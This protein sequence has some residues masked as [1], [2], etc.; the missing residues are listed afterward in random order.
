MKHKKFLLFVFTMAI[1]FGTIFFVQESYALEPSNINAVSKEKGYTQRTLYRKQFFINNTELSE[2]ILSDTPTGT[3]NY[4]GS[5]NNCG[6]GPGGSKFVGYSLTDNPSLKFT[7][8]SNAANSEAETIYSVY[9]FNV[10][11]AKGEHVAEIK[12]STSASCMTTYNSN[13]CTVKLPNYTSEGNFSP[14]GW[15]E[16]GSSTRIPMGSN[17]DVTKNNVTLYANSASKHEVRYNAGAGSS[18]G[19]I[20]CASCSSDDGLTEYVANGE[21][22]IA[23]LIVAPPNSDSELFG[24]TPLGSSV[25]VKDR[26]NQTEIIYPDCRDFSATCKIISDDDLRNHNVIINNNVTLRANFKAISKVIGSCD[27]DVVDNKLKIY[28]STNSSCTM[29]SVNPTNIPWRQFKDSITD[30]EI[31]ENVIAAQDSSYVFSNLPNVTAIDLSKLD[32]SGVTNMSHMFDGDK[33]LTN[34][35]FPNNFAASSVTDMSSMFKDCKELTSLDLSSFN[36]TGVTNMSDMFNGCKKLENLIVNSDTFKTNNVVNMSNMIKD[37]GLSDELVSNLHFDTSSEN[38][39]VKF[40]DESPE[41]NVIDDDSETKT[42][43]ILSPI[44]GG[45]GRYTYELV[46]VDP[47]T[48]GITIDGDKIKVADD[49]NLGTYKVVVNVIDKYIINSETGTNKTTPITYTITVKNNGIPAPNEKPTI[50]SEGGNNFIYKSSDIVLKCESNTSYTNGESSVFLFGYSYSKSVVPT[51]WDES[52]DNTYTITKD[53]QDEVGKRYYFCQEVA[54]KGDIV[55]DPTLSDFLDISVTNATITFDMSNGGT[56]NGES[57]TVYAKTGSADLYSTLMGN[58]PVN[59]PTAYMPG[60]VFNGFYTSPSGGTKVINSDGGLMYNAEGYI[61]NGKWIITKSITLYPQYTRKDKPVP[62]VP[63]TYYGSLGILR[64]YLSTYRT[65]TLSWSKTAGAH[66]YQVCY[67]K[68]SNRSYTCFNNGSLKSV[69]LNTG[70]MYDFKVSPYIIDKGKYIISP[71]GKF[72]SIYTLKKM[73]APKVTKKSKSKVTI[74]YT[75][76][77]G[78]TGYRIY[79]STKKNS[80][81]KLIKTMG[82]NKNSY[83]FK[84]KK[85]KKYYYRVR[86][87][88]V[89]NNKTIYAP[90]SDAKKFKLK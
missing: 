82:Y 33:S 44:Q 69:V 6:D 48:T 72:I 28:S 19:T 85:G 77:N 26:V 21:A 67:K 13:S 90:Y 34:L 73:N 81:Y 50:T 29:S 9:K 71:N 5:D 14:S 61:K 45:I 37:C 64:G 18:S 75:K 41:K 36:T 55:S 39:P 78:V 89:D 46:S 84:P 43:D 20:S 17:Y 16:E 76:I 25:I 22:P 42:I 3:S 10:K 80:G 79:Y 59:N 53:Q 65:V 31:G 68:S 23:D 54:V 35:T 47:Q 49:V 58:S 30:V 32:T 83:S 40:S 86:A 11:F 24:W 4:C 38:I 15:S 62:D 8:T 51:D 2:A 74:K 87:Y 66:G 12:G 60:Y 27:W 88:K 70:T 63:K 56:F 57:T 1:I 52:S 7:N